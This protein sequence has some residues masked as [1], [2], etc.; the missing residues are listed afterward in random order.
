MR[1]I[2]VMKALATFIEAEIYAERAMMTGTAEF[3]AAGG[4]KIPVLR[5]VLISAG[6]TGAKAFSTV[7]SVV[8]IFFRI[9]DVIVCMCCQNSHRKSI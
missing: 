5:K 9:I 7:L 2:K 6:S 3:A 4:L 1:T 8:G